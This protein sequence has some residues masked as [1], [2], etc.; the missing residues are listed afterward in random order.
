MIR[1]DTPIGRGSRDAKIELAE[2]QDPPTLT[3]ERRTQE[4]S[5]LRLIS[6]GD[7]HIAF[8][9]WHHYILY[10]VSLI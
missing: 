2:G 7:A 8:V 6:F 3:L 9:A 4:G 5:D 1:C 10:L